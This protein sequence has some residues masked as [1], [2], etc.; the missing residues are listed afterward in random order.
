MKRSPSL[1]LC[2][3]LTLLLSACNAF[4]QA[5]PSVAAAPPDSPAL[6]AMKQEATAGV[7]SRAKMAQVMVDTVF[8]FSELG[9]H[10]VHTSAYLSGILEQNGFKVE[11]GIAGIPTAFMATWGSGKPVIA[12]GSDVDCIPQASQK[13]GVAYK[14]P[15]VVGAPGHGEG[16]NS[17][18][19]LNILAALAVKDIMQKNHMSGTIK[20]W[21]GIAEELLGAKAYYVRAG[22]FKDV[23]AVLFAHVGNNLGVSYG[24]FSTLGAVSMRFDFVGES[25]HASVAP[26]KGR[27]ALSAVELMDVG[28]S[29]KRQFLRPVQRSHNVI[30]NGGDQPNVVPSTASNWY[31]FREADYAHVRELVDMGEKMAE[32]AAL[33]SST[34]YTSSVLGSAWPG[35]MNK[36][37]AEAEYENIQAVGLPQW[38]EADIAL[39]KGI[40]HE[41]K[42][43]EVGLETTISPLRGGGTEQSFTGGPSDDIGDVSWNVPTI[44]LMY[45]SNIPNLPG[46]NWANSISMATPLAHKGVVA[47]AKAQAMTLLDLMT[48]PELLASAWDYFNNVQTKNQKYV[49]FIR[50]TDQPHLELNKAIMDKYS[51]ALEK[52]YYDSAK[53]PTYL[54]QLGIKYPTL[55]TEPPSAAEV[56]SP[57]S[58]EMP[59]VVA[60]ARA[61]GI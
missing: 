20:V 11:R 42:V 56:D 31:Y 43:P 16:H 9:Y 6:A 47:G 24:G 13:P 10:E 51:P 26:W 59:D 48:K 5:P 12:L 1:C 32:G 61:G 3:S 41:L 38:S 45:P 7:A 49:P 23:D 22:Y 50:P 21:P 53:Y 27:S 40:Q 4:S 25:S 46:H 44:V 35:W 54:D 30:V 34:K 55:R 8:S 29:F 36:P 2:L 39:A 58:I 18:V 15:I 37:I 52:F 33:M 57:D 28:W 19:P 60:A 14:D 17:G